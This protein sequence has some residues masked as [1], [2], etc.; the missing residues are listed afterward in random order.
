MKKSILLFAGLALLTMKSQ[1][2]T[3]TD[4]DGNVY[5]TVTIGTQVWLQQNLKVT[6][7]RNGNAIP[8]VTDNTQWSNLTTGAYCDY[9]NTPSYSTIYGKLYNWYTINTGNLCPTG[10]HVPSDAEWTT[11][12]TYLGGA[13]VAGG[14]L[15]ETGTIHWLSPNTG[16]T[17]EVDFTALPGGYRY[18]DGI[19]FNN[20]SYGDW[21]S[22]TAFNTNTSWGRNMRYSN[23]SVLNDY[24]NNNSG[25]AVR[26]VNDVATR[27]D[28]FLNKTEIK[29]YPNPANKILFVNNTEQEEINLIIYNIV[30]ACI[31]ERELR[32]ENNEI[33]ISTL[34]KGIY[35]I[36]I[37][38]ADWTLQHKLIKE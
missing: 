22:T 7:Y 17:N 12:T 37:A 31:I 30:G 9:N 19:F 26:C 2:Q 13:S 38:G 5:N 11:L 28:E 25:F 15:K 34:Q 21:W 18:L 1:A 35:I 24:G 8:N 6:H 29:I 4:Y 27:T 33:D 32:N 16:A 14:K 20:G 3:V 23:V 10:W 36:K